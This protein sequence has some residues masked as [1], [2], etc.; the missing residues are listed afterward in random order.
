MELKNK[1]VNRATGKK[2]KAK[3]G[4]AKNLFTVRGRR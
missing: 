2:L 4:K 3:N 1:V